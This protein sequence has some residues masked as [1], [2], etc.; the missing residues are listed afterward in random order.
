M[1]GSRVRLRTDARAAWQTWVPR[2]GLKA[3]TVMQKWAIFHALVSNVKCASRETPVKSWTRHR[4]V[5]ACTLDPIGTEREEM[6][7]APP[8]PLRAFFIW[9]PA[10]RTSHEAM[11][12]RRLGT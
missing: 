11:P 12:H 9:S 10:A 8:K 5:L 2:V 4:A 1:T 6:A 3:H 7:C